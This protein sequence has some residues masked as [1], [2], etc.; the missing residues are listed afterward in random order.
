M[1]GEDLF[2]GA[3]TALIPKHFK[4]ASDLRQIPDNQEVFLSPDSDVSLIVEVLELVKEGQA[5]SDP[6]EAVKFHFN[7]LAHDNSASSALVEQIYH[8]P[9]APQADVTMGSTSAP[10]PTPAP[11][12]LEGIQT[13]RK[14]GKADLPE[15]SVRV[16]LALW[17]LPSK[18]VDLVLSLNE[19]IDKS[20]ETSPQAPSPVK[21]LFETSAQS[22][23]IVDW[24]LF[25]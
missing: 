7:S 25:A 12:L 24:S 11:I 21:A 3:I 15:D 13:V 8:L 19:P 14:F 1:T 5:S 9:Q 4:D 17:R 16:W 20:G 22:L 2:G 18:N 23:K 6:V 10:A